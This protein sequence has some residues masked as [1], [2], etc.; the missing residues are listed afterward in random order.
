M[1]PPTATLYDTDFHAWT[2]QQADLLRQG[3][4]DQL[5]TEHLIEEIEDMGKSQQRE[6]SSRLVVLIAHLLKWHFQ[7]DK[8]SR[9]WQATIRVQ[10][11]Q[12]LELLR[13]NPSLRTRLDRAITEAYEVAVNTAWVETGLD[14]M[15]FPPACPYT[16]QQILDSDFFPEP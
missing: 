13:Q 8:R 1:N 14:Y 3:E 5:D 6:L 9:S 15:T 4:Y 10:R 11:H 16:S 7:A 12:L 2:L